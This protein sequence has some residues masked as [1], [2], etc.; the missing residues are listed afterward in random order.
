MKLDEIINLIV[1]I[2]MVAPVVI[3]AVKYLGAA[4]HNK[5]IVNLADRAMIIVSSLDALDI[6]NSAKKQEALNK[7]LGYAGETSIKLTTQQAEDYIESAVQK[8]RR[9]QETTK[10]EVN[11]NASKTKK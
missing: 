1:T 8:L 11:N 4:T 5:K 10:V 7:L 3:E 2:I 6:V 9:L